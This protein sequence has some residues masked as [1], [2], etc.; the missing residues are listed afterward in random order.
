MRRFFPMSLVRASLL[1]L[2]LAG[3]HVVP[4]PSTGYL[5]ADTFAGTAPGQDPD[6][7]AVQEAMMAFA[8]PQRMR[9]QPACMALAV[10]CLDAMA[11]QFS[12]SGRW[13]TFNFFTKQEMLDARAQV[14]A[15]LGIPQ[16]AP[17]QSV[18]DQLV[19]ASQALDKGDRRA[20]LAAL[21]GPDFTKGPEQTLALLSHFP[22]ARTPAANGATMDANANFFPPDS[23]W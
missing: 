9:G 18:I 12:T 5:P 4:P 3:C 7:A 20:A 14:R 17:S 21:S 1:G 13:I 19:A 11:G 8:Y 10:A 23:P 16:N 15:A 6:L 22:F 2:T